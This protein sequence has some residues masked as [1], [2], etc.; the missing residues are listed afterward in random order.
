V[1]AIRPGARPIPLADVRD[2]P[3]DQLPGDADCGDLVSRVLGRQ[4]FASR[5]DV[6]MFNSAI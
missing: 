3:L 5:V 6:A 4:G 2:V 1:S